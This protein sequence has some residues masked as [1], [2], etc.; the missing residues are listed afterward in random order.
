MMNISRKYG[1]VPYVESNS[2][3][4][5]GWSNERRKAYVDNRQ[6]LSF[7]LKFVFPKTDEH[8]NTTCA[9]YEGSDPEHIK[10]KTY[11]G[12]NI[13]DGGL[14]LTMLLLPMGGSY[15]TADG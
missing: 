10:W 1:D 4:Y 3:S 5:S 2:Y 11:T 9:I 8:T 7:N 13:W 15:C 14:N 12:H 6:E